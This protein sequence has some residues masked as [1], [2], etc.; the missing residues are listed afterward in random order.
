MAWVSGLATNEE[1]VIVALVAVD[2]GMAFRF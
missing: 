1:A 2:G